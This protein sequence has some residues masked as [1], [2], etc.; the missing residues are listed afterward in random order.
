[1][2]LRADGSRPGRTRTSLQTSPTVSLE[3]ACKLVSLYAEKES[4]NSVS[5]DAVA[6]A[7]AGRELADA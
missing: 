5:S 1:M 2:Q 6:S 4:P 7:L 3:D